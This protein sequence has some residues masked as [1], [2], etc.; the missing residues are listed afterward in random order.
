MCCYDDH[1]YQN[2]LKSKYVN[3]KVLVRLNLQHIH[4]DI[5][6]GGQELAIGGEQ[7]AVKNNSLLKGSGKFCFSWA[8]DPRKFQTNA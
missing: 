7:E 4:M 5:S 1:F 6:M 2:Q 3:T 8:R